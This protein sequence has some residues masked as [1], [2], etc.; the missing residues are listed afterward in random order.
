MP[1]AKANPY[2]TSL[3]DLMASKTALLHQARTF[4]DMIQS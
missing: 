2:P 1:K 4:T 3:L